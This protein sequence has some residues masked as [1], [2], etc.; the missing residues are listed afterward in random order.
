MP[1]KRLSI[2]IAL[3]GCFIIASANH[4]IDVKFS[5]EQFH[6]SNGMTVNYRL[7]KPQVADSNAENKFPI[8]LFLHGQGERGDDNRSQLDNGGKFFA[9]DSIMLA[10]PAYV[11]FPQCPKSYFWSYNTAPERP[12]PSGLRATKEETPIMTAVMELI[13]SM[14]QWHEVDASRIYVV[15]ISMGGM[16]V[17]DLVC[18]HPDVFAAAVPICGAVDP[19]RLTSA[20]GVPFRIYHGK[21]DDVIPVIASE[22][23]YNTLKSNGG[24]AELVEF[25]Y[26]GHDCWDAAF[27]MPDFLL[28]IYSKSKKAAMTN[29]VADKLSN[30]PLQDCL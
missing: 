22:V 25:A 28:W 26:E 16:A 23:A 5:K 19:E 20:I 12:D 29:G 14:A 9:Q 6:S 21:K 3:L 27:G 13:E 17:Y 4:N 1:Y 7:L 18:R 2:V 11:V 24:E 30:R 8:V 15:G 10:F